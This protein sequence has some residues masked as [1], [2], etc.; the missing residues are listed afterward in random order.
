MLCILIGPH[1]FFKSYR[2]YK[3]CRLYKSIELYNWHISHISRI[4]LEL[5]I[6]S[7]RKFLFFFLFFFLWFSFLFFSFFFFS[8]FFLL[9]FSLTLFLFCFLF[10]FLWFYTL[11]KISLGE[12]GCLRN[13]Y[14][15]GCSS[16]RF[17]DSPLFWTQSVRQ[18]LVT[19][20]SVCS[21]YGRPSCGI[22]YQVLPTNFLDMEAKDSPRNDK[23]QEHINLPIYIDYVQPI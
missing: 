19:Y 10:F 11:N 20:H 5:I 18:H 1:S 16:I 22:G 21:T 8:I 15:T 12:T 3:P 17:F 23:Y 13:P 14:F 7:T 6:A 9:P 2:L 4:I